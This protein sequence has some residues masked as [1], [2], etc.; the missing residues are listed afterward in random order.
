MADRVTLLHLFALY[1]LWYYQLPLPC[2][3][4]SDAGIWAKQADG[5]K[6]WDGTAFQDL[7][8]EQLIKPEAPTVHIKLRGNVSTITHAKNNAEANKSQNYDDLMIFA[9]EGN[10]HIMRYI[11]I[12]YIAKL[13]RSYFVNMYAE[14]TTMSE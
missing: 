9:I 1:G 3:F 7:R 5:V 6:E 11:F 8:H 12:T 14:Y 10:T 13:V 2:H 4:C